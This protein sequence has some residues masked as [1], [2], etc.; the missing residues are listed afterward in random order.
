MAGKGWTEAGRENRKGQINFG[1]TDP[2]RAGTDHGQF[3]YV[4]HCPKCDVNYGAN[5]SD[6][7]Q[8]KCPY[9]QGGAQGLPLQGDE[10][11]RRLGK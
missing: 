5:G 4:M 3:V 8:R 10:P 6:I 11:E 1:R 9:C 2:P 7:W